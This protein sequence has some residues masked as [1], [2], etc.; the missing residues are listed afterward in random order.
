MFFL[1]LDLFILLLQTVDVYI[2]VIVAMEDGPLSSIIGTE[3]IVWTEQPINPVQHPLV[4]R[5]VHVTDHSSPKAPH[6]GF[7]Y[8]PMPGEGKSPGRE[9]LLLFG[10]TG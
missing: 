9:L 5:R 2:L 8:V 6:H 1:P 3:L 7:Q 10:A 4:R